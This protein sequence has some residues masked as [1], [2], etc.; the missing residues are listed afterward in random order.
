M[1]FTSILFLFLFLPLSLG[2]YYIVNENVKEYVL[3]FISLLFYALG[4]LRYLLLFF[5]EIFLTVLIGR[6]LSNSQKPKWKRFLL[7]LGSGINVCLLGYCKFFD[8]AASASNHALGTNIEAGNILLPLGISFFTFKSVSYL[9]DIYTGK[10]VLC[11]N[12]VHDALYLS[13]FAH[14]QSGPLTRYNDMQPVGNGNGSE[15]RMNLFSDGVFRFLIGFN[16]KVLIANVLVKITNEIFSTPFEDFSSAYAWLGSICYSLQLFF[17]FSGYS[18]MAIGTSEMFGYHCMENFNYPYATESVTKFWRRWHISLSQ[19]FRDYVYIPLGGS[20]SKRKNRV[21]INLFVVW[22]L[23][24]VWHGISWNFIAWGLGYYAL[25]AFERATGIPDSFKTRI[26]KII[27]RVFTLLF[28]NLQWVIFRTDD[29]ITGL[30]YIKRMF[31]CKSNLL[32]DLRTVFLIKDYFS[33]ILLAVFLSFPIIPWL[34]KK[35]ED[36]EG[37]RFICEMVLAILTFGLFIWAISFVISGS[38]NPFVYANF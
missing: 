17:D 14:I 26:G 30:R 4:S 11:A 7:L 16:K 21:Y 27:Y 5:I 13:F 33:F 19:W 36:R 35:L 3:L 34:N 38:N 32:A 25:I 28:I 1:G 22:L 6:L 29:L 2:I 15:G 12:P 31:I 10:A 23:T 37:T 8:L 9:V 24:G 18:D 20:R